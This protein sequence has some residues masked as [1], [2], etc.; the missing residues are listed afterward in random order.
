ML[1]KKLAAVGIVLVGLSLVASPLSA[2]DVKASGT[3]MFVPKV[4]ETFSLADGSTVSRMF[5]PGFITADDPSNPLR[6]ASM[7][8]SGTAI[9][10]K[11]G[12]PIRSAGSCDSVDKQGDVAFY[13]WRA[14]DK[15]GGRWGFMGGTGKWA[16]VEG[17]GTY[18]P[19]YEWKDGRQ[20][21]NWKGTWKTK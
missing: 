17:G 14:D 21:N 18:E 10:T 13:W 7:T 19:T 3:N 11:D 12:K 16:N 9:A 2:Q 5:F 20:G 1:K 4:V 8:C 6:L 15:N